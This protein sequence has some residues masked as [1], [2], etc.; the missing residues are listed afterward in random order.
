MIIYFNNLLSFGFW[1]SSLRS[2]EELNI[3][4]DELYDVERELHLEM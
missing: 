1:L 3:E 4:E 2:S